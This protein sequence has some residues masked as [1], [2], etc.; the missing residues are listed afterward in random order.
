[1]LSLIAAK[2]RK[3]LT[4]RKAIVVFAISIIFIVVPLVTTLAQSPAPE[5]QGSNLATKILA[6]GPLLILGAIVSSYVNL[7]GLLALQM[8]HLL[9]KLAQY[10]DFINFGAVVT[11]WTI[12]RDLVNMS[13]V[14]LLLVIAISTILNIE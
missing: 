8:I 14:I 3:I 13:F 2:L 9:L 5:E 1:M 10:N 7:L 6:T 11:G 4:M 12:V